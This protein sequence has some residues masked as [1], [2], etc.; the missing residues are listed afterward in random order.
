MCFNEHVCTED[1]RPATDRYN[2]VAGGDE[3]QVP[4]EALFGQTK[5]SIPQVLKPQGASRRH[6]TP[7]WHSSRWQMSS[8]TLK[9]PD[10]QLHHHIQVTIFLRCFFLLCF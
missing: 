10:A 1:K 6:D 5:L 8:P 2:A 9:F 4:P 3:D 7:Q